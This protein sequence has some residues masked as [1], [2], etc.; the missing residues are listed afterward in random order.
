VLKPPL[1][2]QEGC[3]LPRDSSIQQQS[4]HRTKAVSFAPS[5]TSQNALYEAFADCLTFACALRTS[6]LACFFNLSTLNRSKSER[7]RLFSLCSLRLAQ[8]LTS[9]FFST[10]CFSHARA[11]APRPACRGSFE[12]TM[13]VMIRLLRETD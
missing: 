13:G 5:S 3:K 9:H 4:F 10:S 12:M 2:E 6:N 11:T 7:L 8:A 1:A